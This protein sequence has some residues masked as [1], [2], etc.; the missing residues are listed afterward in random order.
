MTTPR[1][2]VLQHSPVDHPGIMRDFL[3][4]DGIAWDPINT[5][6]HE[7]LPSLD[8]YDGMIVMGGPQQAN[9]EA[10][11]PWLAAEKA[12][13][14]EAIEGRDMPVLGICLGAQLIADAFGGHV[15]PMAEPEIGILDLALTNHG[16]QDPLFRGFP[17]RTTTLQ[18]HLNEITTL[19]QGA[20]HL[21]AAEACE[22]QAFRIGEAGYGLQFHMEI[23]ADM[24]RATDAFPAY[25]AA[26][27]QQRGPGALE[28][29]AA[30]TQASA[31]TLARDARL[32]YDNFVAMTGG[33]GCDRKGEI[34]GPVAGR[35]DVET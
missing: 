12:L 3:R 26:L 7:E 31:H 4:A 23:S 2:L 22:L 35:I 5:Y 13:I 33:S 29:L 25:V 16:A 27:E 34:D 30:E 19:P 14:R 18:W 6:D 8:P 20:A 17:E 24:V 32:I 28:R 11:Y 9:E 10:L 1:L 21:V 15:G